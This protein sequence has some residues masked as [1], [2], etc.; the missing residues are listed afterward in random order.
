MNHEAYQVVVKYRCLEK[1]EDKT[2]AG[3]YTGAYLAVQLTESIGVQVSTSHAAQP[4]IFYRYIFMCALL[5]GIP[6]ILET[7]SCQPF[8]NALLRYYMVK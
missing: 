7:K 8:I 3:H 1:L 2:Y 5:L 6:H 4:E